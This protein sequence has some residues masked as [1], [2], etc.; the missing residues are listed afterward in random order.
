V[1][2]VGGLQM[3]LDYICKNGFEHHVA[4]TRGL[5]ADVLE[6][7]IETYLDWDLYYHR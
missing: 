7:A 3:L 5:V 1:L 4:V 2:R 6:E